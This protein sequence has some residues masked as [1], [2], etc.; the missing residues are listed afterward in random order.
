MINMIDKAKKIYQSIVTV[1]TICLFIITM[2]VLIAGAISIKNGR[3]MNL[4]GFTYSIVPTNSMEPE[5]NVGDSVIGKKEKFEN[6]EIGDDV[7]YHY[8][9]EDLDI[10][11]V[12][13]IIRY[14]EG[15]GYK[16]QGI[17]TSQ[18]DPIYVTKDNYISTRIWNG[19][20]ANIGEI[21][22]NNRGTLFLVLIGI[23]LLI[24]AN[25]VFDIFKIL[26]EKKKLSLEDEK[27]KLKTDYEKELRRQVEEELKN[28]QN[29]LNK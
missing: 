14:D 6:L 19:N 25:G 24:A 17:N 18:E 10:Y 29:G 26:D 21:V 12:H 16:T 7:I 1:I 8:V 23:L 13:R 11:V 15:L 22:L 27:E 28:E 2:Y 9:Y 5:I 3:M 4:F 20:L